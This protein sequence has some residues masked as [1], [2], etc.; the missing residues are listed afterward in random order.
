MSLA[1]CERD[2]LRGRLGLFSVMLGQSNFPAFIQ[3]LQCYGFGRTF[4]FE[5]GTFEWF[6]FY[7][8]LVTNI[9]NAKVVSLEIQALLSVCKFVSLNV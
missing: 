9:I 5:V 2:A 4:Y 3:K 7:L 1:E 8:V 6:F